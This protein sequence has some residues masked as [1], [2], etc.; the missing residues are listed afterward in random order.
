MFT[1]C[2]GENPKLWDLKLLFCNLPQI[3]LFWHKTIQ[4]ENENRVLYCWGVSPG[5]GFSRDENLVRGQT[6]I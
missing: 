5:I 2:V 3:F 6:V 1:I 4:I